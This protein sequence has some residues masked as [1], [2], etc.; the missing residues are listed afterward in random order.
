MPHYKK[1][2][3]FLIVFF[4]LIGCFLNG[5]FAADNTSFI[6]IRSF[7]IDMEDSVLYQDLHLHL[8][9]RLSFEPLPYGVK[10]AIIE[11]DPE[12]NYIAVASGSIYIENQVPTLH[13]VL[14]GLS[15]DG[16]EIKNVPLKGL[17][18]EQ[19][20]DIM[21]LKIR[22]YLEQNISGILRIS[23]TP[24]GCAVLLNGITV[25]TTPAELTLEKGSYV[26]KLQHDYLQTF[27]D[28]VEINSGNHVSVHPMMRFEGHRLKPW[29]LCA[30]I[31]T[32]STTISWIAENSLHR[33]Y[34]SLEE[35]LEQS[36]YDNAFNKYKPVNYLRI[37]LL[38]ASALCWTVNGFLIV[39]NISLKKKIFGK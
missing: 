29:L 14:T 13:F 15:H 32:L 33:S 26:L 16:E 19:I 2:N 35:G 12:S 1:R 4:L 38:N 17:E 37:G 24:L 20:V 11:N 9:K 18:L 21:V 6:G 3:Q 39:R 27:I 23:S 7:K 31:L 5:L 28:T 30:T 36:V 34:S 10:P 25:G 22:Y 8:Y